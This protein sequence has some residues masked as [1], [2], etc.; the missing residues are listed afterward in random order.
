MKINK[1]QDKEEKKKFLNKYK[2]I[3]N[4]LQY[5]F[6]EDFGDYEKNKLLDLHELQIKFTSAFN[7]QIFFYKGLEN[8]KKIKLFDVQYPHLYNVLKFSHSLK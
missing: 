7:Y 6:Q 4:P 1:L 5:T 8:V 2:K 3:F